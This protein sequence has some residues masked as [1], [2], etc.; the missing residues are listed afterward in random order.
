[1]QIVYERLLD[2]DHFENSNEGAARGVGISPSL[3]GEKIYIL[4]DAGATI[5]LKPG[6]T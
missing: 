6:R 4:G 1:M 5:V 3:A 2:L